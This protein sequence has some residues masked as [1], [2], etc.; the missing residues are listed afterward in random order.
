VKK[1][2]LT[3][4]AQHKADKEFENRRDLHRCDH[5]GTVI[6]ET[7]L[8]TEYKNGRWFCDKHCK[9]FYYED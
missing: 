7:A 9:E 6:S 2:T 4:R 5:C 8:K 1:M 3:S